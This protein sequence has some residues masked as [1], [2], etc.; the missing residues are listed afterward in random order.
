M[1][2]VFTTRGFLR[3]FLPRGLFSRSLIIIVTP[4]VLLQALVTY[5]LMERQWQTVSTRMA[6]G[7]AANVAMLVAAH[8]KFKGAQ[9][10]EL[11]SRLAEAVLL[12]TSSIGVREAIA[13]PACPPRCPRIRTCAKPISLNAFSGNSASWH[14]VS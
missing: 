10:A 2:S 14:L 6:R 11:V 4:V 12:H 8:E 5:L 9:Q 7:V 1:P 13:T 3:R